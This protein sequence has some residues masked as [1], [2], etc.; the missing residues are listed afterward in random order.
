MKD[1]YGLPVRQRENGTIDFTD[2]AF[3]AGMLSLFGE[4]QRLDMY[5]KDFRLVRHPF[6]DEND[7]RVTAGGS[8]GLVKI[9]CTGIH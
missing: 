4:E 8:N 9:T 7:Q 1:A 3:L 2:S 5:V 6:G